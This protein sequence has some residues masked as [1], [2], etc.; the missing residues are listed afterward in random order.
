MKRES[1]IE[2][3]KI[4]ANCNDCVF[5]ER[6]FEKFNKWKEWRRINQLR[7][8][9]IKK[10]KQIEVAKSLQDEKSREIE[11]KKANKLT[12][13]FDSNGLISYGK[14][15]KFNKEVSFIPATCQPQ[16]QECFTHRKN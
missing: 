3:Q 7:D 9:E 15:T 12:F 11:L 4:D 8:F 2:L 16:H 10:Q 6:D 13:Q 1:L 14:C 5:L